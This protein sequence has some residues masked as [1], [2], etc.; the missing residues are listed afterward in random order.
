MKPTKVLVADD[1]DLV[2]EGICKLLELYEDIKVV[3]EAGDGLETVKGVR[4]HFPDLVLL[5]LNM[6]RMGGITAIKKIK[7]ISPGIKV[8]ILTIHDEEEYVY[9]VIR[10]GAEGYIQKDVKPEELKRAIDKVIK[11]DKVFPRSTENEVR[12]VVNE[13]YEVCE[14]SSRE[15]EVLELLAQGMSNKQIAQELFISEK[16]V[17][18]HVSN[19]LRKL[20]VNDRTQAVIVALKRGLVSLT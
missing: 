10:S 19:I 14:L 15:Q 4:D 12:E 17:K 9:E 3:G 11:G 8:L 20:S 13:K 2:R 1:H 5:D 16:T 7:E 6:P 18:N